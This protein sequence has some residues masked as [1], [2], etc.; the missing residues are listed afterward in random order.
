[1]PSDLVLRTLC[2]HSPSCEARCVQ[3]HFW[4]LVFVQ[5]SSTPV[6]YGTRHSN[7]LHVECP[8]FCDCHLT[9]VLSLS[10][11]LC[12][13]QLYM[14]ANLMDPVSSPTQPHLFV[15]QSA[16]YMIVPSLAII[17]AYFSMAKKRATARTRNAAKTQ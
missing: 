12:I 5:P 9:H 6:Q 7:H 11:S 10:L 17:R 4:S 16:A 1:M 3:L 8:S 15:L 2:L 14:A 13:S